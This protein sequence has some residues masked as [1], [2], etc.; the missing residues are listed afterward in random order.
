[1]AAPTIGPGNDARDVP[2]A[3]AAAA[4]FTAC[5]EQ[6]KALEPKALPGPQVSTVQ[7]E[8]WTEGYRSAS[9][10]AAEQDFASAADQCEAVVS[11]MRTALR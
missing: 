5:V 4:R 6:Y 3:S 1:V 11:S 9:Q 10:S 8:A 7:I 2:A